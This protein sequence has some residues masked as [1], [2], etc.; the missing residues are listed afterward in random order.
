MVTRKQKQ[1]L[2][3]ILK[4][5]PIK[6]RLLIQGYGGETY[7]G[8]V[9]RK[10][11]DY[12]A[13][14]NIDIEEYANDWDNELEVPEDMQPYPPGSAYECDDIWHACGAEMS[15]TNTIRIDD[16]DGK[17]IWENTCGR[18]LEDLGVV[19]TEHQNRDIDTMP[20]GTVVHVGGQGEKGC[21][22]DGELLLKSPF[23][24]KKLEICYELCGDW[25]IITNVYYDGEEVE[26]NDGYST[27]GKWSEYKWIVVGETVYGEEDD[28]DEIV[29]TPED[30]PSDRSPWW[31]ADVIPNIKGDYEVM[32][33]GSNWPFPQMAT[34][35][36]T[37]WKL[38]GK[39]VAVKE[40][41]GLNYD[42][43]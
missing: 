18:H 10:I 35:T 32:E 15:D 19:I 42:P 13:S 6:A 26:G 25:A 29:F 23:D 39:K 27:T 36:G 17:T 41:R 22:F 5:K 43:N 24:P 9:D 3:D 14:K 31:G 21:F 37:K 12:F 33:A 2:V 38:N 30:E 8:T 7:A 20:V 11:Y 28:S 1:E 34:W 16:E 40:W 4:F